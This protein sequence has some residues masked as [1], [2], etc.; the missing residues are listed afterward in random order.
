[1]HFQLKLAPF[2]QKTQYIAEWD[3]YE[4]TF[5]NFKRLEKCPVRD[6]K[7]RI[8]EFSNCPILKL[9]VLQNVF[10]IKKA[11]LKVFFKVISKKRTTPLKRGFK[12]F[13]GFYA[14]L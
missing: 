7:N 13:F 1:M 11:R 2:N 10:K 3:R 12:R 4:V 5:C 6:I 9:K 14:A 8:L